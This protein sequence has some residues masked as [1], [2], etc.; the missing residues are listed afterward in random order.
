MALT[1]S[2]EET[3]SRRAA[4]LRLEHLLSLESPPLIPRERCENRASS[5]T[6][7]WLHTLLHHFDNALHT[8]LHLVARSALLLSALDGMNRQSPSAR[9]VRGSADLW[10]IGISTMRSQFIVHFEIA[11]NTSILGID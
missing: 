8:A 9:G 4:F 5:S 3:R 6:A 1:V 10:I 2:Y 11:F 7:I